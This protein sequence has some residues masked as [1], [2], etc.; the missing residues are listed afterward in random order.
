MEQLD[1]IFENFVKDEVITEEVKKEIATVFSAMVMEAA[2][3]KFN[4]AQKAML[5]E[6]DSKLQDIVQEYD[7]KF[8]SVVQEHAET[9]QTQLN[10]YL[11]YAA[12]EFVQENKLAIQNS[13]AVAKAKDIIHG[14]QRVFEEH[15]ISLPESNNSIIEDMSKKSD[16]ITRKYNSA[17]EKNIQLTKA[18][19]EA[20]KAVVFIRETADLSDV[21]RDRLMNMMSGLV[22]ESAR[23]FAS[24][25]K[26]LKKIVS[27]SPTKKVN[28]NDVEDHFLS[29][30]KNTKPELE[31]ETGNVSKYLKK[32]GKIQ[33]A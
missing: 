25:I 29:E 20:E 4:R 19:E 17:I 23:D 1:K 31:D 14:V 26:S 12:K 16:S 8:E 32:I 11:K 27:E 7:E 33:L 30:E 15:G 6:Y 18:L 5:K 22:V 21:S 24:K 9:T 28:K 2:E 10:D 13:I 3:E